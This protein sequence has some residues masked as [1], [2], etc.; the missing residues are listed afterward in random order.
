MES[1]VFTD[2]RKRGGQK[3]SNYNVL[4]VQEACLKTNPPHPVVTYGTASSM[5]AFT[6]PVTLGDL[7]TYLITLAVNETYPLLQLVYLLDGKRQ[8]IKKKG[9]R[10]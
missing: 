4:L 1:E 7:L 9:N 10:K 2:E 3:A 5:S 8:E 6:Y